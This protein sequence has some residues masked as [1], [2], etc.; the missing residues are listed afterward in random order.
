M[1]TIAARDCIRVIELTEQVTTAC[2]LAAV[3]AVRL[4]EKAGDLKAAIPA[5]LAGFIAAVDRS[6]PLLE[7]DRPLESELREHLALIRSRTWEV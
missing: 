1:G 4:R 2:L 6:F 5:A 7:A 3:Q